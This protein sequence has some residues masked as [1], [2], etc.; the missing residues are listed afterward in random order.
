M[1]YPL[2][3]VTDERKRMV[4]TMAVAGIP[5]DD[6]AVVINVN[7]KTLKKHYKKE[8]DTG[9]VKANTQAAKKLY[10]RAMEGDVKALMFW[11]ERRG[12][13]VWKHKPQV[14]FNPSDFTID[15]NPEITILDDDTN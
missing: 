4:E 13:D 15:I 2:H 1:S 12:G 6:I 9:L 10:E 7:P 8:L 14:T 5:H 3:K 11:L